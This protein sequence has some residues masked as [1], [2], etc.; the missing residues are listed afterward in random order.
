MAELTLR[1]I[2][3]QTMMEYSGGGAKAYVFPAFDDE[4][5]TYSLNLVDYWD[6]KNRPL[7]IQFVRFYQETIIIEEDIT[8]RPIAELLQERGVPAERI[9]VIQPGQPY[10]EHLQKNRKELP[11]HDE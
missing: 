7:I 8:D 1:E 3:K 5:G 10:P 11:S 9:V 4:H 2:L 6:T